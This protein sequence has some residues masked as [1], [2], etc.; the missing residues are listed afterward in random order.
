[1]LAVK[2]GLR[3]PYLRLYMTFLMIYCS[4]NDTITNCLEI[5]PS[6]KLVK[7]TIKTP[8]TYIQPPEIKIQSNH[9][10]K[11]AAI[12]CSLLTWMLS[13][14]TK[15]SSS[16]WHNLLLATLATINSASS[17]L[18]NWSFCAMSVRE[19]REYDKLI[20]RTP[21]LITLCRNLIINIK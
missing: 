9:Q 20:I 2:D 21:A 4:I 6:F 5:R 10:P 15:I 13:K 18:S 11:V 1:M 17:G 14:P 16:Y 19:I 12:A 7:A 8:L 3:I